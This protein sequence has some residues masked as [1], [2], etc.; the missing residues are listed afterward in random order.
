MV[1]DYE[2]AR[3]FAIRYLGYA[4]RSRKQVRDRLVAKEFSPEAIDGVMCLLAEKG[5]IDDVA[6]AQNYISHKTRISNYGRRRIV[7]GLL[8]KGVRKEDIQAAYNAILERDGEDMTKDTEIEAARRALF[9]WL[10]RKGNRENYEKIK[11]DPK[12]YQRLAAFLMRRGFSYDI[13]KKA[14]QSED[15]SL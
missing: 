4:P 8:Q 10:A 13:I 2:R 9:K 5:Y 11:D 6:F 14:M 1:P 3:D 15:A 7:V 12:E